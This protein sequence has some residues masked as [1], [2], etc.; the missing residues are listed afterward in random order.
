MQV[1][2]KNTVCTSGVESVAEPSLEASDGGRTVFAERQREVRISGIEVLDELNFHAFCV[3]LDGLGEVGVA[4][5]RRFPAVVL[6]VVF[7]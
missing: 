3:G 4:K 1:Y 5:E 7:L 6:S 2:F